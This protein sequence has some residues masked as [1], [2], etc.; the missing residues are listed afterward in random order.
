MVIL[1]GLAALTLYDGSFRQCEADPMV[2]ARVDESYT[3][4]YP[5]HRET[6]E[7][8]RLPVG[9]GRVLARGIRAG[10]AAKRAG[11]LLT[12][13]EHVKDFGKNGGN[14]GVWINKLERLW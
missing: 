5:Y 6:G 3:S 2:Y 14:Y 7:V 12:K 9:L 10:G 1:V 11:Y 4:W 13:F 8:V